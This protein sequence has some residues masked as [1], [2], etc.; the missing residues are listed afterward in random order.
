MSEFGVVGWPAGAIRTERLVLRPSEA[1]DRDAVIELLASAEVGAYVGGARDRGELE[2]TLP[3]VPGQ[4]PGF[5]VVELEGAAIGTVTLDAR[6]AESTGYPEAGK[7]E[8]GY[9]FLPHAWGRGYAAEACAAALTWFATTHPG[10]SVALCTQ[11]A[12]DRSLRLA[13]K[14]GFTELTRYHAYGAEQCLATWSDHVQS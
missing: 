6:S 5:F 10:E 4:R 1:R 3:E 14:L 13:T 12:N 11:T 7:V 8:L 2:R 9:L